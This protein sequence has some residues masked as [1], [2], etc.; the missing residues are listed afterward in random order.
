L[1]EAF[2]LANENSTK[3][4]Y[5]SLFA[6]PPH[7]QAHQA[8]AQQ[9]TDTSGASTPP[10]EL[11]SE[12]KHEQ[13]ARNS[14]VRT[15]SQ[16]FAEQL[17][18]LA[19]KTAELCIAADATPTTTPTPTTTTTTT[20][21]QQTTSSTTT[22]DAATSD[23]NSTLG[24][25][26]D[27]SQLEHDIAAQLIEQLNQLSL[28]SHPQ[29]REYK[30]RIHSGTTLE[31]TTQHGRQAAFTRLTMDSVK[32]AK[33][34]KAIEEAA[35]KMVEHELKQL[36]EKKSTTTRRR[37]KKA[38]QKLCPSCKKCEQPMREKEGATGEYVCD[39]L[40]CAFTNEPKKD[41][42]IFFW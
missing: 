19:R 38:Q 20:D 36:Q 3:I 17:D 39:S 6:Q 22:S 14:L 35:E 7:D 34:E 11:T 25:S 42:V 9:C 37:K 1:T 23:S 27:R 18:A 32:R 31:P 21:E 24:T 15:L 41:R 2:R 5:L 16:E 10:R 12:E 33:F 8:S 13:E 40:G 29:K 4:L 28:E 30:Y 26:I